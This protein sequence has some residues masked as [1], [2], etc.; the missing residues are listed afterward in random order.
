MLT[1]IRPFGWAQILALGVFIPTAAANAEDDL[2]TN[3]IVT[4]AGTPQ[5]RDESG[6]AITVIDAAAITRAQPRSVTDILNYVPSVRVN[7]NGNLGAV[8]GVSLRGAETG[9]TLVLLDGVR[10]NDPS[11]PTDAVDFGNLLIGNIRRIEVM[12]GSNAIPFGSD[13]MGGVIDISTRD[14]DAREGLSLRASGEGGYAGTA[15]GA[16]DIGWRQGDLRVDAGIVGLTTDGISTAARRF[17]ATERDGLTNWTGHLRIEA[18][19]TEGL[20]I[21]LRGYGVDAKFDNDA[22]FGVPADTPNTNRFR[23]FTGYAGLKAS[24][25][26]DALA[27]RLSLTWLENGRDYRSAPDAPVDYGYRGRS[28]RIDYQGKLALGAP[29]DLV[30]G[31]T[32]DAPRYRY[33]GFGSKEQ[34]EAN[35]DSIHAMLIVRPL[36]RLTVTGGVRHDD[37]NQFGGVTTFGANGNLGLGD[38]KTRIRAAYGEGFN[39]PSLYQLYD[40]WSGNDTLRPERSRSF[41]VG[42]DRSFADGKGN[43]SLTLFTRTTRQQIG[44]VNYGYVNIERTRAQGV[45]IEARLSPGEGLNATFAYSLVDTRDRSPGSVN[46][47]RHLARRPVHGV[48]ASL[49]KAWSFGLST[50]ATVRMASDAVDLTAPRDLDGYILFDLRVSI[51][52][53][54]NIELYGRVENLFD[55][56]YE[57]VYGYSTFGRAAY[58]GIRVTL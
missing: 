13:A 20:S 5:D 8:T 36:A 25:F 6:Q 29:A 24:S 22:F 16:A 50:G 49:D 2:S 4:A 23:Q 52:L 41:D 10:I 12:R 18:P 58:G 37:H 54:R 14:P 53:G 9:Q 57:T 17:G 11:S 28:W 51:P 46:Y 21:D 3:I 39:T 45:E 47:D 56:D 40:V 27:S 38:G 42:L 26:G 32:H 19:I 44:Y 30:F 34:H 1:T 48:T 7:R 55:E 33:S 15:Q 43:V 35:T 31:Y